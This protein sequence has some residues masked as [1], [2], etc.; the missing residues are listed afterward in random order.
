MMEYWY[1]ATYLLDTLILKLEYQ[2]MDLCF[3]VGPVKVVLAKRANQFTKTL[4][5]PDV[6]PMRGMLGCVLQRLLDIVAEY[7]GEMKHTL[8]AGSRYGLERLTIYVL[9]NSNWAWQLDSAMGNFIKSLVELH[10]ISHSGLIDRDL[11][12]HRVYSIRIGRVCNLSSEFA[13]G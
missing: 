12:E 4:N 8:K 13:E 1:E 6:K 5:R 9:T 3:A 2:D 10:Q 7:I 11:G